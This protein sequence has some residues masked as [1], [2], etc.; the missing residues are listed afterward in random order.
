MKVQIMLKNEDVH[1]MYARFTD[2]LN[3]LGALGKT[4]SNNKKVKK[5]IK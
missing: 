5:I 2:T 4:L 1:S 3:T